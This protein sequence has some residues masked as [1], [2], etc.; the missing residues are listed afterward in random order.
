VPSIADL[1]F[2]GLLL[3]RLRPT[4]FHDADTGWHLWAGTATL[5]RGPGAIPDVLSFTRY[6][7]PWPNPEWLGEVLF[8]LSYRY[9]DYLGVAL[10]AGVVFAGTFSWLYRIL[11]REAGDA[12]AALLVT[13]LAAQVAL[14]HFLARP[15]I[16]SLPLFVATVE[17]LRRSPG[18]RNL[19][20]LPLLTVLWANVHP[21]AYLAPAMAVYAWLRSPRS[22]TMALSAAL[23]ALALGLTPWGFG[24]IG[25]ALPWGGNTGYL[26]RITEWTAPQ[27]ND[28]RFLPILLALVLSLAARR[29][30]PPWPWWE[31]GWGLGWLVAALVTARLGPYAFLAWAPFLARDLAQGA[32]FPVDGRLHRGWRALSGAL[33]PM[34]RVLRPRWW[35]VL[36]GLVALLLAPKLA[37]VYPS[38]ARGFPEDRFPRDALA[39]ADSLGLGP[40]VFNHYGWGGYVGWAG[41]ERWQV[42]IDGRLGFFGPD[43]FEDYL[44]VFDLR[45]G[46]ED[47]LDRHE[48]DWLLFPP[49]APVVTAAPLSGRW[50][51]VYEDELAALLVPA[52]APADSA[53]R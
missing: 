28:P 24:W 34:E 52:P 44:T 4:L 15:L 30:R 13:V 29:N 41:G 42:F 22:R 7:I 10:L 35:P 21:S 47:V 39:R 26:A 12:V 18:T 45:P 50:R 32:L 2:A 11:L 20:L 43:L 9:A 48:P 6:G 53:R 1:I 16:F 25:P 36:V 33:S 31:T 14:I 17:L 38:V 3:T 46:W 51:L 37:P 19:W 23:A 27:F 8:A 40:R 5:E 49:R